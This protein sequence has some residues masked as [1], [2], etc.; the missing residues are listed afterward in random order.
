MSAPISVWT[1]RKNELRSWS[2]KFERVQWKKMSTGYIR[3][4]RR[5]GLLYCI[6]APYADKT[7]MSQL[8]VIDFK[9]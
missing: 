6:L 9:V 3:P 2:D 4:D 7:G 5:F 1:I 8:D